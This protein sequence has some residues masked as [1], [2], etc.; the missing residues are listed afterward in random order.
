MS[1]HLLTLGLIAL[2]TPA[3]ADT[4]IGQ[5]RIDTV[6]IYPGQATVSRDIAL[7]LP[8]GRHEILVPGLPATLDPA[9]LRLSAPAGVQIGA[10]SL[11]R[12]R[13]PVTPDQDSAAVV[14]ARAAVETAAETLRQRDVQIA[15]IRLEVTALEDQIAFLQR[16]SMTSATQNLDSSSVADIQ[17]LADMVGSR[18]LSLRNQAFAAEERAK[19]QERARQDDLDALDDARQA[20]DALIAP[21]DRGTVLTFT[22]TTDTAQDVTV[23]AS[24]IEGFA[25]WQPV[26]DLRLTTGESPQ[27]DMDR[28]VV[29]SQSTGQDWLDATLILSTARPGEQTA[30]SPVWPAPRRIIP[31]DQIAREPR[32]ADTA[33]SVNRDQQ[34]V[35]TE[36][37]AP[38]RGAADFSGATVIYRYPGTVDIRNGVEDLRLPLDTLQLDATVWA[39]A[40][41][42]RD[43]IA[44]RVAEFTNTTQEVLLPGQVLLFTD[45]TMIG[46]DQ[47]PLLAAGADMQMGFGPLDRI[48][49][50]RAVP[51]RTTG[52]TG[53][54]S[55][56]TQL[57]ESAVITVENLTDRDWDLLLRDTVPYSE[58]DDL[59]VTVTATPAVTRTDPEGQRGILEW[60]L[61]LAPRSTQVVRLDYTLRWPDGYVLR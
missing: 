8:A 5:A 3:I 20:L 15:E 2:T 1:R 36:M 33:L 59:Q 56:A 55:S 30:P 52:D 27:I 40:A 54:F 46:F 4:I 18:T 24:A 58:Q 25:M 6:T 32:M 29:V 13:L 38:F 57:R 37:A 12:D 16:L 21:P 19:A 17:A 34:V 7:T 39:E 22:L 14:A 49:L 61:L 10:V 45:G 11:A 48:R 26:Y 41:P 42:A 44:Y 31:E 47:L 23:T 50:T 43:T 35:A 60:D 28:S 51:N 53:L 9:G